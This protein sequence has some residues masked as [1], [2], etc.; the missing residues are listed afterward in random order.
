M[1][2]GDGNGRELALAPNEQIIVMDET[3]GVI[4]VFVGPYKLST[5]ANDRAV[6][7]NPTNRKFERCGL[8]EAVTLW[9]FAEEGYYIVLDN[10]AAEGQE[11]NPRGGM[12]NSASKLDFGRRV[13]IPGPS[14]FPLWPGQFAEVIQ[15]HHLRT[16]EY[17]VV[18]VYNEKAAKEN[19]GKSI[20]RP[21]KAS[22]PSD[23]GE[24]G[25]DK[26]GA[27]KTGAEAAATKM[28]MPDL[29]MG[30]R[31]IVSG[32][33]VSFYIPPTGI[34]VVKDE[35]GK[36]VRSAVT[37]ERLEYCILLSED[38]NK[39]YVQGPT[40]VFPKPDES[41]VEQSGER[42][43]KAIELSPMSGLYIRVTSDYEEGESVYYSGDELFITGKD[44]AIY[45]PRQEH[46]IVRYGNEDVYFAVAIPK[47]E[48]RY[49]LNRLTG[50]ISLVEGPTMFL[51][52]PRKEVLIKRILSPKEAE[53]WYPGNRE[54]LEYNLRLADESS[55]ADFV[56]TPIVACAAAAVSPMLKG[57]SL[58]EEKFVG[59][60]FQRKN[61]FTKPRTITIDSKY[62]G[63]V[64][65]SVWPG[66]AILVTSKSG[67][68]RVVEGPNTVILEYH[69]TLMA[70]ELST[71]TPKSDAKL[72][73]TVYLHTE[74]NRVSDLVEVETSDFC[75]VNVKMAYRVNF[76]GD[77]PEKWFSVDNYVRLLTEHMRSLIRGTVKRFGIEVFYRDSTKIIRDAILGIAKEGEKRPGKMFEENNMR[78]YDV[79]V[80]DVTIRDVD[81]AQLINSSQHE[82]V[83]QAIH[84]TE[85]ERQCEDTKR[86]E[87]L[88]QEIAEAKTATALKNTELEIEAVNK[89]LQLDMTKLENDVRIRVARAKADF[90]EAI[91]SDKIDK[92]NLEN[93]KAH[94]EMN[95]QEAQ[96][97]FE[98]EL[99]RIQAEV[100]A[101]VDKAGAV[102]PD[103][104]AALKVFGDQALMREVTEAMAPLAIIDRTSVAN[105]VSKL[106][107]GT[108][109]ASMIDNLTPKAE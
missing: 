14:T 33:E 5:T 26:T 37:L 58:A 13:I 107:N 59:D 83:K 57:R 36:Y 101:V 73:R 99:Q 89:K 91:A 25:A 76:E 102:S 100:K 28:L 106:F 77:K 70:M 3:K 20:M 18:R 44:Q 47:G 87:L 62:D 42:K 11:A 68:R 34:T 85:E 2:V 94:V 86:S 60:G 53:L 21:Q 51:P 50:A 1:P 67:D 32:K 72:I 81:I 46:A 27:D 49:V 29:T 104:I 90:D 45:Y 12:S 24:T 8:E 7:F 39:R 97:K 74:N 23:S 31:L 108:P 93:H 63:A 71:G 64:T 6:R 66:Y 61:T 40:V 82:A 22:I 43:F 16:D 9:P 79:E 78:I 95:L 54:A 10:P 88:K 103:L 56:E 80:L 48:A 15:G 96:G 19:W 35:S 65:V 109:L 69:E 92:I 17:L 38:G 98:I 75:R 52:D 84:I 105:V 55:G 30:Q 4:N 41:F